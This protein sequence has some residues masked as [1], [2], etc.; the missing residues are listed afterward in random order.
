[1]LLTLCRPWCQYQHCTSFHSQVICKKTNMFSG[2]ARVF[3]Q[4]TGLCAIASYIAKQL[5]AWIWVSFVWE[6]GIF[7]CTSA[8][9]SW[10]GKFEVITLPYIWGL[11][12][13]T[14]RNFRYTFHTFNYVCFI[15]SY[16]ILD[17]CNLLF[18]LPILNVGNYFFL[19][20]IWNLVFFKYFTWTCHQIF[21]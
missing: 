19:R 15:H 2:R 8:S 11:D 1:M 5:A 10:R 18:K 6:T 7:C 14:N 21:I 17:S 9:R 20:K 16:I 3:F 12:K 13:V 4:K